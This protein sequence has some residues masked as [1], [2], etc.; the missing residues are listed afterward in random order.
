MKRIT[1]KIAVAVGTFIIGI[2]VVAIWLENSKRNIPTIP[3]VDIEVE[4]I[5]TPIPK[6]T[7]D[8]TV[9]SVKFCELV[10][11]PKQW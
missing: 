1:V 4:S 5:T 10:Q 2:A 7:P 6:A 9:Y 11:N 3:P 8:L